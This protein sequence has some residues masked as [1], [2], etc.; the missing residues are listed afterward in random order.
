MLHTCIQDSVG[1]FEGNFLLGRPKHR[2][3]D[4]IKMDFKE[5]GWERVDCIH[6]VQDRDK[7]VANPGTLCSI[8]SFR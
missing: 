1:K 5:T 6:L 3:V 7:S 4:N 8:V 2:C